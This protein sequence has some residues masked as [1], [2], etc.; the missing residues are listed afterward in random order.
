ML[1]REAI[2]ARDETR[3][4]RNL[5]AWDFLIGVQDIT[6][7]GALRFTYAGD[8][9]FLADSHLPIP[10]VAH[11]SELQT[12]AMELTNK[13]IEDLDAMK[14]WLAILVAPGSSLGGARP[15]A[16]FAESD[17]SLWIAKF[18]AKDDP[19]DM[20]GL[21]N[22]RTQSRAVRRHFGATRTHAAI[23]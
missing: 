20:G 18:P 9:S 10:P 2:C 22:G 21:G 23:R 11:L 13:K 19:Y 5:Y 14:R 12:V 8:T 7:Q 15:K 16:S 4:A 17:G 1:R 3:K 6:R